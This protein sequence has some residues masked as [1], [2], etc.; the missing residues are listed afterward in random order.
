MAHKISF[1]SGRAEIAYAGASPWHGLGYHTEAQQTP[2]RMLELAG[3][4]WTV[5]TTGLYVATEGGGFTEA[6]PGYVAIRRQDTR[7]VLGVASDRYTPIQNTQAGE[8]MDAL[9]SEGQATVEVAGALDAGHRCWMLSRIP[10]TFEVVKGDLI[11]LYVLLAWGHDGKH[12]LAM[13]TM[14]TRVV[15]N[16]TLTAALG[17]KWSRAADFYVKHSKNSRVRLEEAQRALGLVRKQG[18]ETVA[19]YQRLAATQIEPAQAHAYFGQVFPM[20]EQ[21]QEETP[22]AF[23]QRMDRWARQQG[24]LDGLYHEGAG[25]D[26]APETAWTAYNAVTEWADHVYPVLQNGQVSTARQRSVL[27]GQYSDTKAEALALALEMAT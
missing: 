21:R 1:A 11:S 26:L 8:L 17:D 16:N 13:K 12:G 15:C 24:A 22:E 27:L 2:Q 4:L 9:V 6:V 10:E 18:E 20:P 19:A 23:V 25:A 14:P 3:L 7:A 5:E